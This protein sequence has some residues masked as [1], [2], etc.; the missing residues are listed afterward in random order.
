MAYTTQAL[1]EEELQMKFD[2][3][4]TPTDSSITSW[5]AEA[6]SEIDDTLQRKFTTTTETDEYHD[7]PRNQ[8]FLLLNNRPV[9]AISSL[10]YNSAGLGSTPDWVA[11][12]EG[13]A[14]DYLLY[15]RNSKVKFHSLN[16]RIPEGSQ[17]IKVTYTHGELDGGAVPKTIQRLATLIVSE[18]VLD[19]FMNNIRLKSPLDITLGEITV[20]HT[21]SAVAGHKKSYWE[22]A[23]R[24]YRSKGTFKAYTYNQN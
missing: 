19:T 14:D 20:K 11:L 5:I 15:K 2:A 21:F 4:S 18:R 7:M 12:T 6:Q 24:L 3:N 16:Y 8:N 22:K 13:F 10:S 17:I 23:D 1:I 9:I